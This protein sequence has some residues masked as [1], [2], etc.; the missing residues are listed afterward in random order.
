MAEKLTLDLSLV[1]PD[2]SSEPDAC[3]ARLIALLQA[4]GLKKAHVIREDGSARLCLHYDPH[5]RGVIAALGAALLFYG[6]FT[7][8]ITSIPISTLPLHSG[9]TSGKSRCRSAFGLCRSS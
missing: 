6:A 9:S 7:T 4:E 5:K 3:V 1:L 2:I 8:C